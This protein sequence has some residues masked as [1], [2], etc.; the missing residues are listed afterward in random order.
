MELELRH[1]RVVC[2]VAE[3]GSVTKAAAALGLAQPALT[4]QLHRIERVLGGPLFDRDHRGVRPT[5]MGD[6]VIARARLL[7][8]AMSGLRDDAARL[9]SNAGRDPGTPEHLSI[10][11]ST[12]A[13]LGRLIHHL[14]AAYADLQVSTHVSWSA[15]DLAGMLAD[16]R[17]DFA[18]VGVCGDS[19]PPARS[20]LVWHTMAI[21][22][23]FVLVPASHPL[24]SEDAVDLAELSEA[25][26]VGTPGDGCFADCFATACARAGFTPRNLYETDVVSCVDL[27]ESGR[28]IALCQATRVVPGLVAVPIR[29]TPLRWRHVVG[30]HPDSSAAAFSDSLVESAAGAFRDLIDRSAGYS[31]W[32]EN[33]PG[34]FGVQRSPHV[35]PTV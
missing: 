1:L 15:D 32:L 11:S 6:M 28:A 22:P 20:G 8:P 29:G 34:G 23:V 17:L 16:G 5:P 21:D 33:H 3:A 13:V 18:V 25:Q 27:V 24:A 4:A 30:W 19:P 2:A 7:L 10:G 35:T 31:A 12:G 26:W 14:N 9:S